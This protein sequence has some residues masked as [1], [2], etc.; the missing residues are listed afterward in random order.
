MRRLRIAEIFESI[1]GEGL[2]AGTPSVFVRS[3]G[4][5]LRC[6]FCDT[7]YTSWQPEGQHWTIEEIL[8]TL[9]R[10]C[11]RHAVITGGEP[12]LQPDVV[13]LSRE[14]DRRGYHVTIETAGTVY[15]PVACDLMSL[16]PKLSNSRPFVETAVAVA[17]R[18]RQRAGSPRYA[19]DLEDPIAS[20]GRWAQ[21]HEQTRIH[22]NVLHRLFSEYDY[23]VKFVIDQPQDVDEVEAFVS[24]YPEM[25]RDRVLLM[26]QAVTAEELEQKSQW[27]KNQCAQRAFGFGPRLQIEQFGNVRGT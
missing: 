5:N 17:R 6:C 4:C 20:N 15:R 12:M 1:Q 23:Q 26:P 8:G 25:N 18:E 10:S 24:A 9:E 19:R 2:L 21:R 16:S 11:C 7:P 3:T 14:L 13:P 22:P 27:I